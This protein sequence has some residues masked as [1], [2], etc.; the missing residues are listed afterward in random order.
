MASLNFAGAK[1]AVLGCLIFHVRLLTE[2]NWLDECRVQ[3]SQREEGYE[4]TVA[5]LNR[6]LTEVGSFYRLN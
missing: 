6:R 3:L 1:P 5:E 4:A 2:L